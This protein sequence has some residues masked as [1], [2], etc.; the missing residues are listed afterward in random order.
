M[1]CQVL[2]LTITFFDIPSYPLPIAVRNSLTNQFYQK[3]NVSV[4]KKKKIPS[5]WFL[6]IWYFTF[7]LL[8]SFSLQMLHLY[9]FL[10]FTIWYFLS[11]FWR[12]DLLLNFF[13]QMSQINVLPSYF[14]FVS[15]FYF[16]HQDIQIFHPLSIDSLVLPFFFLEIQYLAKL[17]L[18]CFYIF[19]WLF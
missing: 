3:N 9:I 14:A 1:F 2:K 15:T 8:S 4:Y 17:S 19:S 5:L 18:N 11:W 7:N 12:F 16:L 10:P 6:T 13:I